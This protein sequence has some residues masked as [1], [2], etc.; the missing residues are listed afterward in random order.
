VKKRIVFNS[1]QVGERGTEVALFDYAFANEEILGNESICLFPRDKIVSETANAKFNKYF[2]VRYYEDWRQW[3]GLM[4]ELGADGFYSIRYGGGAGSE[5]LPSAV[6]SFIHCVFDTRHPYGTVCASISPYLNKKFHTALPVMPHIVERKSDA[7]DDLRESLGINR[8]ATVFGCYGGRESFS[9]GCA[10]RAVAEAAG[11][12]PD[13]FFLFMNIEPFCEDPQVRF[14]PGSTDADEKQRFINSCDAML[15][16]RSDGETFGLSVA[17][18]FISGKPIITYIPRFDPRRRYDRAHLDMLEGACSVY[19]SKRELLH[20]LLNF[21][22]RELDEA[23]I[24]VTYLKPYSR[25]RVM[26]I[27]DEL[28]VSRL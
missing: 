27:F 6:P 14:L 9:V 25:E 1:G 24:D 7:E 21:Q 4:R 19:S 11:A 18:F 12:R 3:D 28:F 15:H 17:E 20:I 22:K 13:I 2:T 5:E 26:G 10:Q 23:L 8:Q 16:A